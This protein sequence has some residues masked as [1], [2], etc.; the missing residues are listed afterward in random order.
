MKAYNSVLDSNTIL[1]YPAVN[2]SSNLPELKQR[3]S[4]IEITL[5][6]DGA[7]PPDKEVPKE[8]SGKRIFLPESNNSKSLETIPLGQDIN[9]SSN[10]QSFRIRQVTPS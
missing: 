10:P 9:T 8:K 6:P 1:N 2:P 3:S 4:S 5:Q 7:R